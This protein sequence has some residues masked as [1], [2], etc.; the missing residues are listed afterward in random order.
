MGKEHVTSQKLGG[1]HLIYAAS[2]PVTS[3]ST[4]SLKKGGGAEKLTAK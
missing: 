4:L 2:A 3:A 1:V